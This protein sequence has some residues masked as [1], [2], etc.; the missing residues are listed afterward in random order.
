[1]TSL[2]W[3]LALTSFLSASLAHA[4]LAI[5]HTLNAV[6]V[7]STQDLTPNELATHALLGQFRGFLGTPIDATH[8]ITAKHIGI[9]QTDTIAF[10]E[11]PNVGTYSIESWVDDPGSDLRIVT[12][13]G[14]FQSWVPLFGGGSETG[15]TAT[16]FG[17]GGQPQSLVYVGTERKGWT[18]AGS[19]GQISWGRNVVSGTLGANQITARFEINGIP[20]EAGLTAGDSGGPW[21]TPDSRGVL[22]LIGISS[23]T[24]GPYE[25]DFAGAPSGIQFQGA[26]FDIGGLWVG[27]IGS[28]SFVPD[29]PINVPGSLI[30]SRIADRIGWISAQIDLTT[31]DTDQDGIADQF[32]N[33]PWIVNA[34]QADNGGLGSSATADG[35]G[36]ACQCG[37]VTGE[38]LVNDTDAAYIKRQALG[39]SAPLFVVSK[40]CDVTGDGTCNGTDATLIRQAAIGNIS[41][42]FGQNCPNAAP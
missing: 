23:S 2:A 10:T 25:L 31:E 37:D 30:A 11:G 12:I 14:T 32:D 21:L 22:R 33:C 16:I 41:P 29:N 1:M 34:N 20:Y 5:D 18:A 26:L 4:I 8:F 19:D 15:R 3:T 9:A 7:T 38:G 39:L 6:R 40:N 24:T 17:R 36:N 27:A 35:I 28:A 42:L 13:T